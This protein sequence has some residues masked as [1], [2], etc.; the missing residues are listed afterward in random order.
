MQID[1]LNK[2][3]FHWLLASY[4]QLFIIRSQMLILSSKATK[5]RWQM[6]SYKVE[7]KILNSARNVS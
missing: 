1:R 7:Q 3:S 4:I 2:I 6:R 5:N